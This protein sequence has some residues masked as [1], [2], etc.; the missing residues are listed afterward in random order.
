MECTRTAKAE[1]T[2]KKRRSKN[3]KKNVVV[4]KVKIKNKYCH[5]PPPINRIVQQ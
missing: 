5:A 3:R 1:G 2:E 4:H